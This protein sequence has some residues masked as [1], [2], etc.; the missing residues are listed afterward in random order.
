MSLLNKS[1]VLAIVF[2]STN[3]FA[4]SDS[5]MPVRIEVGGVFPIVFTDPSLKGFGFLLEPKLNL[6]DKLSAGL[7]FEWDIAIR[8]EVESEGT[9]AGAMVIGNY[10]AKTDYFFTAEDVRPFIG[11]GL[12]LFAV[13][14]GTASQSVNVSKGSAVNGNFFG[15]APQ[16]GIN[17]KGFRFGIS[18]KM[19]FAKQ[20][21]GEIN[22]SEGTAKLENKL[23]NVLCFELAGSIMSKKKN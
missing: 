11:L 10:C 9:S 3:I 12:G 2:L 20:G 5:Y 23:L 1:M 15:F 14:G 4:L 7:R 17:L 6:T 8:A 13:T 16:V 22:I 19:I 21:T 18:N